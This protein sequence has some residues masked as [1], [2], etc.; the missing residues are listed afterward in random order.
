MRPETLVAVSAPVLR[1]RPVDP[2][3]FPA[4]WHPGDWLV[5]MRLFGVLP[6]GRQVISVS[7]EAADGPEWVLRDN[8]HGALARRWDHRITIAPA[9]TDERTAY[10]DE[11]IVEAGW[12]TPVVAG[13][14]RLFYAHRQRRWHA[15]IAA[16]ALPGASEATEIGPR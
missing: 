9:G 6:L 15:L 1:L 5:S 11:V 14:A 16:D 4:I 7:I 2:P 12:L 10:R 13:F 3:R 8:G